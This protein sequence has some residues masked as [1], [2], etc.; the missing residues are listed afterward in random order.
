[1]SMN[2][3]FF[4]SHQAK[5]PSD[6]EGVVIK[7][8]V[9]RKIAQNGCLNPSFKTFVNVCQKMSPPKCKGTKKFLRQRVL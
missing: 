5:G 2:I 3:T 4:E 8:W 7:T 1:M 6:A 9:D